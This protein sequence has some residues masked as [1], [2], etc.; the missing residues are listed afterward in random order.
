MRANSFL[1]EVISKLGYLCKRCRQ[2]RMKSKLARML[3]LDE[4]Q[5]V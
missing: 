3:T 1:L 4:A 2:S 5:G